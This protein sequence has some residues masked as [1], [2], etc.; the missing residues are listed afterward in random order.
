MET[1][2]F[3]NIRGRNP[4]GKRQAFEEF[5]CQVARKLPPDKGAVFRR[6]EGSG[7]DGG[8]EAY[9]LHENGKKTGYQAKY[10][11]RTGDIDW[12]KI[13]LSVKQAL[14]SHPELKVY[15]VILA[16]D[17][18][19]R[20]GKKRKGKTGWEHWKTHCNKWKQWAQGHKMAIEFQVWT[21]SDIRSSSLNVLTAGAINYWFDVT[22]LD[23]DWF[24]KHAKVAINDLG[25]RYSPSTHIDTEARKHFQALVH[26]P[27]CTL[28]VVESAQALLSHLEEFRQWLIFGGFGSLLEEQDRFPEFDHARME[29]SRLSTEVIPSDVMS[30]FSWAK[31]KK[32]W[33][34]VIDDTSKFLSD[35]RLVITREEHGRR[36]MT[37][38]EQVNDSLH[39]LWTAV[40]SDHLKLIDERCVLVVGTFGTGKSH[41]LGNLLDTSVSDSRPAILLLGQ[42][43]NDSKSNISNIADDRFIQ[44]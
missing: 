33:L 38:I 31:A 44:A 36:S 28:E 16:C 35:V 25:A 40:R 12:R 24:Q 43:F 14:D 30:S 10:W 27:D 20:T 21:A 32:E 34:K 37:Q 18:T 42:K 23:S 3:L 9:W 2:D 1:I 39:R 19:D 11:T 7:G 22:H 5:A 17:L 15:I 6:V 26:D 29:L 41:A 13:D 8:V 4:A